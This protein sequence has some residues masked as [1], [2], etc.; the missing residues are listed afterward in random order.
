MGVD[1]LLQED[2]FRWACG[3]SLSFPLTML[4]LTE[5]LERL[6]RLDSPL[7]SAVKL[8]RQWIV[9]LA[10]VI[11]LFEYVMGLGPDNML[12]KCLQTVLWLVMILAAL[13]AVNA[14][15]FEQADANS[16]QAKVPSLL[17]DMCRAILVLVGLAIIIAN[18]WGADL[19][20][21]LGALGV[22]SLVLGLALQDSMGNLFS[23]VALLFERP[24]AVDDWLEI[25]E[26]IG[27]V[28]AITWRSVHLRTPQQK[29]VI[30]P[31]SVLA[32]GSFFNYSRPTKV[33]GEEIQLGFS[34][35]DPPNKVIGIL[36]EIAQTTEEILKTPAPTVHVLSY[37]DFS[38]GYRLRFFVDDYSHMPRIRSAITSRV[39][40]ASQRYGLTMP[41]PTQ[42]EA[43][44]VDAATKTAQSMQQIVDRLQV[45]P[46]LS[47]LTPETLQTLAQDAELHEYGHN[48]AALIQGEPIAGIY[49]ILQGV[50]H[51]SLRDEDEQIYP[52]GELTAGD[53]FGE[54]LLLGQP[55]SDL[56]IKAADDLQVIIFH[57][58]VFQT[59]LDR[60]PNLASIINE[61]MEAR[62]RSLKYKN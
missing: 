12:L 17:I 47:R 26:K 60:I 45:L 62:R 33:H 19:G 2:W 10:A 23:G 42:V 14:I 36:E 24:F 8:V 6:K 13:S 30:V 41:F 50:A 32:Q 5:V 38:I 40:Y 15:V 39:W 55:T 16:W 34:Y 48:E 54:R 49:L 4:I 11:I 25:D 51:V 22:G 27:R 46:S 21:L 18:V 20:G 1:K 58:A 52:M 7:R 28:V 56:T 37:D 35:D 61:T 44:I 31:N 43:P 57:A 29:L 59:L 53:I 3:L 9:P